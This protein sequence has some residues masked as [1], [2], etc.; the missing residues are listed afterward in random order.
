MKVVSAKAMAELEACAYQQGFKEKDFMENAGRGIALYVQEFIQKHGLEHQIWLLCGKGNNA[1]DAFVAGCYLLDQ[2]YLVIAIQLEDLVHCSPLCQQN[3]QR[4]LDKQGKLVRQIDD[5]G[6]SGVI[7]DGLFGTGFKGQVHPPYTSLIEAAN[8]SGLPILAIDIPSGLN[9]TT[10]QVEGSVIQATETIFL[11]LPKTG[12]FLEQ[13]W[14]VTGKLQGVDFGLP[15]AIHEQAVADFE[16][17]MEEQVSSLLPPIRRNRHKYQA[18]YV[19]GVAG[20]PTMPGAALLSCLAAFR[21]GS[22]MVRLLYP[23]G[24][25][26]E[27]SSSPYELI[28]ISYNYD[29]VDKIVQLMQK[30]NAA[31]VGPGLGRSE[32]TQHLLSTLLPSLKIPCVIDADA[33]TFFANQAF[34]L[35]FQA[36]FTPHM[37]EMQTLL[38]SSSRL[39]LNSDLLKTCQRY[40]EEHHVTLILKGSPTFIFHPQTPIFVNPTGDPGMATAGSGDVLTGLLA[41]LLSQGLG[42]HDA[43]L[44]GVYLHG[45]AGEIAVEQR[46]TSYGIMAT[47][48]IDHFALAYQR[49][50]Q[51]VACHSKTSL[52]SKK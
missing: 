11:G 5:F 12:F 26:A 43:A 18:G 44:L 30:A 6:P 4:F 27:L 49:L 29:R 28:K 17:L 13:G 16:L 33:L 42:C 37:G 8:Q 41:S 52:S 46:G 20:S 35:P 48:L 23:Q 14:N 39:I 51:S 32:N 10:G 2:G 1:G 9:G 15:A 50:L 40:A 47:D 3:G 19:I 21:G 7:L 38:K 31:F 25:E 24:M 36:I 34:E 45:L 22:G